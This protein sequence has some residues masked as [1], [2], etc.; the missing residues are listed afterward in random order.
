MSDAAPTR[1]GFYSYAAGA[2]R[3]VAE[4]TRGPDGLVRLSVI[5]PDRAGLARDYYD[6]GVP[7]LATGARVPPSAGDAFLR[8]LLQPFRMTYYGFVDESDTESPARDDDRVVPGGAAAGRA[9]E[10]GGVADG[11]SA[12]GPLT[13]VTDPNA[14]RLR[15]TG[16]A[17][18]YSVEDAYRVLSGLPPGPVEVPEPPE[19]ADRREQR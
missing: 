13:G 2:G 16:S 9:D 19:P 4:F 8:A 6:N 11:G 12:E 14:V 1:V 18:G 7:L 3:R 10:A 15:P 5:D 17:P